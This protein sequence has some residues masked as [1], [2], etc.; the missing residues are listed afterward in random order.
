MKRKIYASF[1]FLLLLAFLFSGCSIQFRTVDELITPPKQQEL[2]EEILNVLKE[3]IGSVYT[4]KI[5][6]SGDNR[7][8]FLLYDLDGDGFEEAI[9]FYQLNNAMNTVHM[10]L[11]RQ[12][13]G[14][15]TSLQTVEGQGNGVYSVVFADL[16]NDGSQEI[17]IGWE[18]YNN[19]LKHGLS[20]Y[21]YQPSNKTPLS[22]VSGSLSFAAMTVVDIDE[23]KKKELLLFTIDTSVSPTQSYAHLYGFNDKNIWGLRSETILDG[24]VTSYPNVSVQQNVD[25]NGVAVYVDGTKGE[26]S[27]I[28]EMIIWD[29]E[30]EAIKTVFYD[31]T[32]RSTPSTLR[33]FRVT[34]RDINGDGI[35]EIPSQE[36]LDNK[37]LDN[38][39]VSL[40]KWSQVQNGSLVPI[41]YSLINFYDGYMVAIPDAWATKLLVSYDK[42]ARV[43]L[44]GDWS[45]GPNTE[46]I[47]R[48]VISIVAMHR[49]EWKAGQSGYEELMKSGDMV[50]AAKMLT[51]DENVPLTIESLKNNI[52]IYM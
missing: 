39:L 13:N 38:T 4:L 42:K 34:A 52:A 19:K 41:G 2:N 6:S 29:K 23:D 46:S 5:P 1:A 9:A 22:L 24:N 26:T 17:I 43:L 27:M 10:M 11:F 30:A 28:T 3:E 50:C 31:G 36:A 40:V 25:G 51:A 14:K 49:S 37:E 12:V 45:A 48:N 21:S 18:A 15:W 47:Q 20:V 8:A 44:L 33:G 7:S 35:V 32:I 16:N